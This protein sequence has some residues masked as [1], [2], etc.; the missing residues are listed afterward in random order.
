MLLLNLRSINLAPSHN[1]TAQVQAGF[2]HS[3]CKSPGKVGRE[4]LAVS[5]LHF[6]EFVRLDASAYVVVQFCFLVSDY[7]NAY[8]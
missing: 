2:R 8:C 6:A 5:F 7:G 4:E 1:R 3:D